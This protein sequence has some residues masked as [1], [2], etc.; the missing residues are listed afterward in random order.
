MLVAVLL[1]WLAIELRIIGRITR[2]T[3][4]AVQASRDMRSA[5][6]AGRIDMAH[7]GGR[8][9]LGV[10]AR[11]LQDLLQRVQDDLR[12]E[13]IR[14]AQEKDQWHAV[15]HEIMSPLQSLMALH[16][17]QDDPSRRYV[18]RMQ[19]AVR[20][21]YGQASPSEAF[22]GVTVVPQPLELAGFLGHLVANAAQAGVP[23]ALF[24]HDGTALWVR[25]DEYSLEDVLTH[26]LRNAH[27]HRVPG[28]PI[29]LTLRPTGAEVCVDIHN[30]GPPIEPALAERMFEYG[31]R[32][33][34]AGVGEAEGVHR[35]QGLFVARTYMAKMGGTITAA[36]VPDGVVFTLGLARAG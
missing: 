12:R 2:L 30:Q 4:G 7:L 24:H 8:D 10:L 36:N 16:G 15:G 27:R 21:L 11:T 35:G 9:E 20:V 1:A 31:V 25:A 5:D 6:G 14:V 13:K 3:R 26:V 32:G 19:Q 29:T 23:D 22:A 17:A 18:E 33:I 34:E 28:T